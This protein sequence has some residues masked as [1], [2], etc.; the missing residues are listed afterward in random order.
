MEK[1]MRFFLFKIFFKITWLLAPNKRRVNQ[2]CDIYMDLLEMEERIKK[3][4]EALLYT[5][6]FSNSEGMATIG[7][8]NESRVL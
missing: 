2:M 3:E 4:N 7:R 8:K 6:K 5:R 1:V